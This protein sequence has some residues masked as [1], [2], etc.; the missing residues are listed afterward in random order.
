MT[1][2]SPRLFGSPQRRK[3]DPRLITGRGTYVDDVTL[4]GMLYVAM[5]RSPHAHARILSIDGDAAKATP[6]V[7]AVYTGADLEGKLGDLPCGVNLPA[8]RQMSDPP[9]ALPRDKVRYVGDIVA[10]VVAESQATRRATRAELVVVDYERI[11]GDRRPGAAIQ[12]ARRNS[13]TTSPNN[14]AFVWRLGGR[15]RRCRARAVRRS[16]LSSASSTSA[17]SRTR[18]SRAAVPAHYNPGT[19]EID[20]LDDHAEPAPDPA[21]ARR[22]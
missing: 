7:V 8:F 22:W 17:S 18:W 10:V 2:T 4:P 15:Q 3:E 13:M 9:A 21:A 14:T 5:V 20:H 16:S 12:P 11:A 19:E 6:G 1:A